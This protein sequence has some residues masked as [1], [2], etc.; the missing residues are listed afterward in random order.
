MLLGFQSKNHP[1]QT[2]YKGSRP[3]VDDR[4]MVPADFHVLQ[5]RFRFTLDVA[6][7][8][9]NT[10]LTNYYTKQ[11]NG[12]AQ[13]WSGYRVYCNP[14]YSDIAPWVRKA[15]ASRR[16]DLVVMVLPNNRAEQGWWQELIE[17][18]R[19]RPGSVLVTENVAG[20]MRFLKP[21]QSTIKPN[22]RPPFG[23]VL[24]VWYWACGPQTEPTLF[25]EDTD[26][27]TLPTT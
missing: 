24:C 21:G 2:R 7:S 13:D 17:P 22:E 25:P 15:W 4:A 12:L 8:A 16:S 19:D 18:Y 27:N 6:A 3:D 1:Q 26:E 14:P 23:I 5:K 20:R 11:D 10:K 9:E